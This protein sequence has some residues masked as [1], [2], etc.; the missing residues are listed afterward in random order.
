MAS[1]YLPLTDDQLLEKVCQGGGEL[2]ILTWQDSRT[3]RFKAGL[4]NPAR[5]LVMAL[6]AHDDQVTATKAAKE[7]EA[8]LDRLV[9]ERTELT[10]RNLMDE[11]G[12]GK[13]K[14]RH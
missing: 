9:E 10:V 1:T 3:G 8:R 5:S 11:A 12:D 7:L 14:S 13:A 4:R 2:M 6:S